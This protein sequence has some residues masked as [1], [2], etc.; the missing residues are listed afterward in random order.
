MA[1]LISEAIIGLIFG[2][3]IA[4]GVTLVV[5]VLPFR[6]LRGKPNFARGVAVALIP[7]FASGIAFLA[8]AWL[9]VQV[10]IP[11]AMIADCV[12]GKC[13]PYISEGLRSSV[14]DQLFLRIV[15]PPPFQQRCFGGET[16]AC[17]VVEAIFVHPAFGEGF[18]SPGW[19]GFVR[20]GVL[21]SYGAL[22]TGILL[23]MAISRR[24]NRE[25]AA[26]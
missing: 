23:P 22:L 5:L 24:W 16:E 20:A 8:I 21:R 3:P 17:A 12:N 26:A 2:V 4:V 7:I 11:F 19:G 10:T 18:A 9:T 14:A 13:I 6:I 25:R 1:N 15:A